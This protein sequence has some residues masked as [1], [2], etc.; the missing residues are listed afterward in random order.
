MV[1]M[2]L[3]PDTVLGLDAAGLIKRI[4]SGVTKFKPGDRVATFFVGAYASLIHTPESLVNKIPDHMTLEEG[5]S[6]PTVYGTAYQGLINIAHLSA[7][8]SIL[9]HSAAGGKSYSLA[10][11]QHH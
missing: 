4:G 3:I 6:L 8:E 7:G 2:G 9:I 10:A 5:A 1:S 11:K